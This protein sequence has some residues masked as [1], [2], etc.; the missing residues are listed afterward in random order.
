MF[1]VTTIFWVRFHIHTRESNNKT[2]IKRQAV[3]KGYTKRHRQGKN[4]SAICWEPFFLLEML[5][6]VSEWER[7]KKVGVGKNHFPHFSWSMYIS[8]SPSFFCADDIHF[9]SRTIFFSSAHIS[10]FLSRRIKKEL[11][12]KEYQNNGRKS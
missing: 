10:M 3:E 1:N 7:R 8:R 11:S 6:W 4:I 5:I 2:H 12:S 9:L